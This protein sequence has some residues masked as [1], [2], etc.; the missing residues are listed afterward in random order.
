MT[1]A[2]RFAAALVGFVIAQNACGASSITTVGPTPVKCAVG[3]TPGSA[4]I[5]SSGGTGTVV[6]AAEPECAWNASAAVS[7]ISSVTPA[8]G[9]GN[10][11]VAF[12]VTT[13]SGAARTGTFTIADQQVSV[14]Q[15]SGCTFIVQPT[16]LSVGSGGGP[17]TF[18]VSGGTG[19]TRT[20][21]SQVPWITVTSGASGSGNGSV[22]ATVAANQGAQRSGTLLIA[23]RTVTVTQASGCTFTISQ[24]SQTFGTAGGNGVVDVTTAAGC[25]WTATSQAVWIMIRSGDTGT[26]SGQ[27]SYTVGPFNGKRNGTMTIAGRTFTVTQAKN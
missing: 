9:Q 4:S 26:G 11:Q 2:A 25:P 10:G 6:V 20:S 16:S 27:V 21:T 18:T 14:S 8:S 15:A 1:R 12:Q 19:C 17:A 3:V 13:N 23:E 22:V 7:W 24:T 5:G